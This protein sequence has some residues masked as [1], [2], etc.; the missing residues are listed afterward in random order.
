MPSQCRPKDRCYWAELTP[1]AEQALEFREQP[2]IAS[3]AQPWRRP[4]ACVLQQCR[5]LAIRPRDDNLNS[6]GTTFITSASFTLRMRRREIG[7]FIFVT[8]L[9]LPRFRSGCA[10]SAERPVAKGQ[11]FALLP[12]FASSNCERRGGCRY[13]TRRLRLAVAGLGAPGKSAIADCPGAAEKRLIEKNCQLE[14][15]CPRRAGR[16]ALEL[17]YR[18]NPFSFKSRCMHRISSL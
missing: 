3:S 9:F 1:D 10:C 6:A 7:V 4:V 17:L 14:W 12:S 18:S 11:T 2:F 5:A 8:H 15:W 13:R 16:S